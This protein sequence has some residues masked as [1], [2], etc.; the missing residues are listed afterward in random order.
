MRTRQ[1]GA[2]RRGI[3]LAGGRN[4]RLY[5]MTLAVGKSLLPVYDKPMIYY[6]L[7]TL[8]LA[9]I[10]DVLIIVR[11]EHRPQF[12]TL[13]GDGTQLGM[14]I[15]YAVQP[16]A[17]GLADAFVVGGDFLDGG[18]AA[19]VLGDNIFYGHGL[20]EILQGAMERE[21]G[22]TVFAY[23][24]RDPSAY[25]V[26]EFDADG[27]AISLEEKPEKP[28]S[29]YAVTGLYFFDERVVD[30]ATNVAPSSRGEVEIVDVMNAYLDTGELSV[31]IFSRGFAWS[32]AG[33]PESLAQASLFVEAIEARQG[34]KIA[35]VEEVAYRMGFIDADGLE[36]LAIALG[37]NDYSRYLMSVL[38]EAEP[39]SAR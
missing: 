24:V 34:L 12:E 28:R 18:P 39:G 13:L 3:V 10:R 9:G 32:D 20:A 14:N 36:R 4:T 11:P 6:P 16:Q 26:V 8:M 17:K 5:P 15:S 31:E 25:G 22:G 27:R 21:R 33:T 7:S 19:L 38:D 1:T 29:Q 35:C 30:I 23:R 37:G 2:M